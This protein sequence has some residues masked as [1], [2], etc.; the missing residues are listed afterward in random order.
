LA[1]KNKINNE[2]SPAVF[3]VKNNLTNT[4]PRM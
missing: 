2:I 1:K 3:T 4:R